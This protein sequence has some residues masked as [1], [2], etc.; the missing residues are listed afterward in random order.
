VSFVFD[1]QPC[2]RSVADAALGFDV[3]YIVAIES[4][5]ASVG[6]QPQDSGRCETPGPSGLIVHARLGDQP[7]V[8]CEC[9]TGLCPGDAQPLVTLAP[10]EYAGKAHLQARDWQGPSDTGNQ[11]GDPFPAGAYDVV[12]TARGTV[13][14]GT[15]AW[16]FSVVGRYEMR[17]Q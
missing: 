6:S 12:L 16:I 14:E 8:Y 9:D 13:G 1:K 4:S 3:G 11:P 15:D 7:H 2:E 10:G 5:I 17:L